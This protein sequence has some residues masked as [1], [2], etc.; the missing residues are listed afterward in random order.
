[1]GTIYMSHRAMSM[2]IV[3]QGIGKLQ[4][5][6]IKERHNIPWGLLA[7]FLIEKQLG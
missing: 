7:Q 3:P 1:M 4:L 6:G 2:D 5:M